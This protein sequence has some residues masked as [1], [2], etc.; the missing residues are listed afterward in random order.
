MCNGLIIKIKGRTSLVKPVTRASYLN[1][2]LKCSAQMTLR[3][4]KCIIWTILVVVS[5]TITTHTKFQKCQLYCY[6][7][8]NLIILKS[9]PEANKDSEEK[10][11]ISSKQFNKHNFITAGPSGFR[12]ESFNG[13][14]LNLYLKHMTPKFGLKNLKAIIWTILVE[15]H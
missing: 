13:F 5:L 7:Q 15:F 1:A 9:N 11:E 2:C 12:Q 8:W 4:Y 14:L 10:L 3:V 6:L